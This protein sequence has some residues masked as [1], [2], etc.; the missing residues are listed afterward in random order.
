MPFPIRR[1][2]HTTTRL[3]VLTAATAGDV[4]AYWV[5]RGSAG[6]D[7]QLGL[8]INRALSSVGYGLDNHTSSVG[9]SFDLGTVNSGDSLIFAMA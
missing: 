8:L 6:Y 1:P 5:G 4:V 3:T 7:N 9:D 2:G